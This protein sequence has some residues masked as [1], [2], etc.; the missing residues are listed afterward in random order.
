[1]ELER[2]KIGEVGG[3]SGSLVITDSCYIDAYWEKPAGENGD[4]PYSYEG[5]FDATCNKNGGGNLGNT[6]GV[7]F[8]S[9]YGDGVYNVYATYND[10]D[11]FGSRIVKIEIEMGITPEKKS[12]LEGID[13]VKDGVV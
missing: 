9:G 8:R 6:L 10:D 4:Y 7:A 2:K 13:A 12:I 1:M 5:V 11:V 3:D